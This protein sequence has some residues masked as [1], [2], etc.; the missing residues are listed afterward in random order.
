MLKTAREGSFNFMN[1]LREAVAQ[2]GWQ[3]EFRPEAEA[4][5][6]AN[7][8]GY[9]LVHMMQAPHKRALTF[10]RAYHY[11]FWNIEPVP[12][13]WRFHVANT[14]FDP[15]I[16]PR[17]EAIAFLQRITTRVLPG[18]TPTRGDA[19]L[20]PLQGRI[21]ISRSFQTMSPVEMVAT[22]AR[23]GRRAIATLH[24]NETYDDDDRAALTAL[25]AQHPNLTIGGNTAAL[26]RDCAF[27][28]TQNSSVAFD[29]LM[30]GKPAVLFGQSD[31]HH[32][33]LNVAELGADEALARAPGHHPD[34]T[35]YIWWFLRHMAV[36]ATAEDAHAQIRAAMKRGGWPIDQPPL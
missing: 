15:A 14:A 4:A 3:T 35:G 18:P 1:K 21:R 13:R 5:A 23:T 7:L 19:V 2:I 22:V 11:P 28:A 33:A 25:A 6:S 32:I 26:L 8:P 16:V 36:N 27:V 29:G 31:F 24:P 10:R 17:D 30:L 9:A 20:I 12:Q 34:F